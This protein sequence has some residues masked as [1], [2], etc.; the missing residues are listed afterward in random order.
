MTK[1]SLLGISGALRAESTNRLLVREAAR[2]FGEAE[3]TEADIRFPLFDQDIEDDPGIPEEV[4]SLAHQ[5]AAS[6]AVIVS[7]PEYNKGI[8]GALKNALDWISRTGVAP[9]KDKPV[10]LMSAAA[11]RA[12]GERSQNMTRLCL[13]PFQPR[14]INGPE[15]MVAQTSN[16]WDENGRLTNEM[17]AKALDDLM[18]LLRKEAEWMRAR[19]A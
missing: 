2:R 6:D 18:A 10:A 17:N 4:M 8:S 3:F 14:I 1:L 16:Q 13:A 11:G 5:I 9:W 7:T 12:G 19:A 15:L